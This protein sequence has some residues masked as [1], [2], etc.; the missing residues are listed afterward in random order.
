MFKNRFDELQRLER[1]YREGGFQLFIVYGRRR[2]GKTTLLL[3]FVKN[4]PAIFYVAEEQNDK[5]ALESF[6]RAVL[7]HFKVRYFESFDS[8][9]K[10]FLFLAERAEKQRI[11][12]VIDEFPYLV[13]SNPGL[14]S[15]LQRLV[16]HRLKDTNLF[17]ILC[18]SSVSFMEKEVLGEKSPLY[19]R[20][21]AQMLVEPMNFFQS[22]LFFPRYSFE[23]QVMTYA[24][25]GGTPK[26]LTLF[27]DTKDVFE[28]VKEKILDKTAYLYE[29]P[30]FLLRQELR[31]PSVYN[32][33]IKAIAVGKTKLNEIATTVG[34]ETKKCSKYL[35]TLEELRIVKTIE[36][37]DIAKRSRG[38]IYS[39]ADNFFRFWYR[40]VFTNID[41]IELGLIDEVLETKIKPYVDQ[42]VGPI[43]EEICTDYLKEMNK[44][45]RL[46]FVFEKIGRWW[47]NNPL[48]KKEQEIDIVAHDGKN[49]LLGE[50]KWQREKVGIEVYHQLVEKAGMFD[51]PNKYYAIFSKSGFTDE[52]KDLAEK[53][54]K[55]LLIDN[56]ELN[57]P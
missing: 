38:K 40:F 37:V 57:D 45:K 39:L 11:A 33:I 43:F 19:G 1:I 53:S 2:V 5:L 34:I 35:S 8:W 26:Y 25:L 54:E 18:G 36:P 15:L 50:C 6:S 16:D 22:R 10:L 24:I 3:E 44:R 55:L 20:R 49:L 28:N 48:R 42:F 14:P 4:K 17:L 9:E 52:L 32:S 46:P 31:E 13:N 47:G 7:D 27:D 29:E 12:V 23:E 51:F 21:T 30:K 56:F 41:M